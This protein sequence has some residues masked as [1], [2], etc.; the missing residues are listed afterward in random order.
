MAKWVDQGENRVVDILFGAQAVDANTYLGMYTDST[1]PGETATLPGG[2]VPITEISGAG[3]GT[4]TRTR[5]LC[6]SVRRATRN[7]HKL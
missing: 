1:E 5:C 6:L 4:K 3:P 7:P 2:A